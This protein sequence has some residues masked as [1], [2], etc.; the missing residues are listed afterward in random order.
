MRELRRN[1]PSHLKTDFAIIQILHEELSH[2][3]IQLQQQWQ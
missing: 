2:Y 1:F 3:S